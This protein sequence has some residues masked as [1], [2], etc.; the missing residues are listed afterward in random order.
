MKV[1]LGANI[2]ANGKVLLEED[3]N[4]QVPQE[5]IDILTRKAIQIGNLVIGRKTYEFI[6]QFPGGIKQVLSGIEIVLLSSNDS[7]TKDFKV[8]STPGEAVKYLT[9]KGFK[10]IAVGGGTQTYN[11]FLNKDLVTDIY[12]NIIPIITGNGG[13]LGTRDE[14]ATKFKLTEHKLLADDI[15][16]LHLTKTN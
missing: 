13:I 10:E 3:P 7:L 4:H 1:I 14:L 6:Q 8:V 11:A 12:F 5:A 15:V 2:S 9:E 16:Q